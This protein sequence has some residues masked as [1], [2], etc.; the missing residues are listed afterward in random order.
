MDTQTPNT[1]PEPAQ[2]FTPPPTPPAGNNNQVMAIL[3]YLGI[4]VIVP[5]LTEAKNDPFVKFH[6][7]QGLVL[8][9]C[10]V[11][12]WFILA[13]PFLGWIIVPV[14]QLIFLILII[15]GIMNVVNKQMK[16]LPVIGAWAKQFNF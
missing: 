12:G 4:L 11:I 16:E 3:A 10:E 9:I 2:S 8:L 15:L 7:K 13:I 14:F 1:P 6:I 5:F